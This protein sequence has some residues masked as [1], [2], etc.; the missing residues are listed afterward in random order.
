MVTILQKKR[1]QRMIYSRITILVLILL[2]FFLGKAVLNVYE[3]AQRTKE[4]LN[5]AT[6]ELEN[7]ESRGDLL[8]ERIESFK[9]EKG[10]EEEIRDK[11]NVIK[12]GEH[13]IMIVDEELTDEDMKNENSGSLWQRIKF[14]FKRD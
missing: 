12:E 2:V 13:V 4:N 5:I 3:K 9:T 8:E 10:I 6:T 14:L 1:Y 7:L 11:F